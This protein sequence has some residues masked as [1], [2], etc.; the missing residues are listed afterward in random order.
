MSGCGCAPL[1]PAV[2]AFIMHRFREAVNESCTCGGNGPGPDACP[3]CMVWHRCGGAT[4]YAEWPDGPRRGST[5]A[6]PELDGRTWTEMPGQSPPAESN[7][8]RDVR[9]ETGT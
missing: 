4:V 8:R 9:G 5:I 6:C 3:A 7:A 1:D 2:R